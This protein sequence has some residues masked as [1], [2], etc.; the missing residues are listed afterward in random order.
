MHA[1]APLQATKPEAAAR[2]LELIQMRLISEAI[3][4]VAALGI[5]DLLADGP[6]SIEQLAETAGASAPSLG[7]T[8]RALSSFSSTA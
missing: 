8:M 1:T 2:L 7:R 3:H 5:A 6:R 4:V